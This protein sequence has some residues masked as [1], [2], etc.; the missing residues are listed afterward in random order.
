MGD[1]VAAEG[2]E[3][4]TLLRNAKYFRR[5]YRARAWYARQEI[6]NYLTAPRRTLGHIDAAIL[7]AKADSDAHKGGKHEDANASIDCL[8]KFLRVQN[9]LDFTGKDI[10]GLDDEQKYIDIEGLQISFA[11]DA[12]I[13]SVSK[14]GDDRI[15]GIFLNTRLGKGLGSQPATIEKRKKAGEAVALIGL[16]QLIDVYSD[17][18]EPNPKDTYHIY[19]RA[20]H[21]WCAPNS[22]V[23][24]MK[25]LEAEA[26]TIMRMWETISPPADFDPDKAKVHS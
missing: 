25:N 23:N 13:K 18:G 22:Y 4:E 11:F 15:G 17:I 3:R 16:R 2:A 19:I 6:V 21:F 7:E 5:T 8:E 9:K 14:A 26:R 20:D 24:R 12:L 10:V 1:F